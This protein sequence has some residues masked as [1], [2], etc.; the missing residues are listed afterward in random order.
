VATADLNGDGILDLVAARGYNSGNSVSVFLG[1]GD[2]TFK[3]PVPYAVGLSPNG[4]VVADVNGDGKPDLVVPIYA[5]NSNVSV[6]LGN[7]DGTFQAPLSMSVDGTPLAVAVGD[8]NGDGQMDLAVAIH[9][10][11]QGGLLNI[12]L[13]RGDGTFQAGDTYRLPMSQLALFALDLNGDSRT[14]LLA[15]NTSGNS[16][17]VLL[18]N[19]NGTF[20]NPWNYL[21]NNGDMHS[22]AVGDLNGDG[23]P[24]LA[25]ANF[26]SNSVS[27]LLNHGTGPATPRTRQPNTSIP[28][29]AEFSDFV[30]AASP[31]LAPLDA[32]VVMP[33]PLGE[34]G[35]TVGVDWLAPDQEVLERTPVPITAAYRTSV[36]ALVSPNRCNSFEPGLSV[37][38]EQ[39][40]KREDAEWW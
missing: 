24:D 18:G 5:A 2:G 7:G 39:T 25:I 38:E 8:F 23:Q 31:I 9:N 12:L 30:A 11:L 13:G 15:V 22:A 34:V 10:P 20:Q 32:P 27:V 37:W 14:D 3:T 26:Y 35:V 4:I 19:G 16:V 33:A 36:P 29:D 21:V 40:V 28:G 1:N 17:D 6:L